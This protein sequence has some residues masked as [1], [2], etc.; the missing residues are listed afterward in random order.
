MLV[1]LLAVV[2]RQTRVILGFISYTMISQVFNKNMNLLTTCAQT[3]HFVAWT[4]RVGK[5]LGMRSCY[6]NFLFPLLQNSVTTVLHNVSVVQRF[7]ILT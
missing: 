5:C 1:F 4:D 7:S 6:I 3:V 2:L